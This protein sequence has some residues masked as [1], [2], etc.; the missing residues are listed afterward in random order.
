[1]DTIKLVHCS[2]DLIMNPSLTFPS[3]RLVEDAEGKTS[4]TFSAFLKQQ[5]RNG[6]QILFLFMVPA[7]SM[8][9]TLISF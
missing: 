3:N 7:K 4:G 9:L 5:L 8:P 1:M 6:T 2:P